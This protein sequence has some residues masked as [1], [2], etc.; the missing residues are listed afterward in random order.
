[1]FPSSKTEVWE[2]ASQQNRKF[3]SIYLFS[4]DITNLTSLTYRIWKPQEIWIRIV[5]KHSID[6]IQEF[7]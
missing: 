4:W 7:F 6:G 5:G 1:M 2:V 3:N